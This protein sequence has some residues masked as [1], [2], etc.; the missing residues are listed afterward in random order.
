VSYLENIKYNSQNI[1]SVKF[2][3]KSMRV[4]IVRIVRIVSKV[5]IVIIVSIIV[6]IVRSLRISILI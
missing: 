2:N 3:S 6:C 1:V 4:I 5:I